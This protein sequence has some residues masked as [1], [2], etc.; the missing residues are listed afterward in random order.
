MQR[1]RQRNFDGFYVIE[2]RHYTRVC[3]HVGLY[4]CSGVGGTILIF[5]VVCNEI[6]VVRK[7]EF[8]D[9]NARKNNYKI[10]KPFCSGTRL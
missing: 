4:N 2:K 9:K 3:L 10:R 6:G 5:K 8:S 7:L 1:T